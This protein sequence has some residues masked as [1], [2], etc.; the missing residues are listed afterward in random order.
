MSSHAGPARRSR[1]N[2][3]PRLGP[4]RFLVAW[5]LVGAF[6]LFT[7]YGLCVAYW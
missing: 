6:V 4:W 3:R 2:V 1:G 7:G 5:F